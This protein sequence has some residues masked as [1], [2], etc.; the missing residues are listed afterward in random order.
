M[1][2]KL[3]YSIIWYS[4]IKDIVELKSQEF[5]SEVESVEPRI[6]I[7]KFTFYFTRF[8]SRIRV[9]SRTS[10]FFLW[11]PNLWFFLLFD[12]ATHVLDKLLVQKQD[13]KNMSMKNWSGSDMAYA[14]YFCLCSFYRGNNRHRLNYRLCW[15]V[16]FLFMEVKNDVIYQ[17]SKFF[18][19]IF[20]FIR[21]CTS[22]R[23]RSFFLL[24]LAFLYLSL[25]TSSS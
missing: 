11:R 19:T 18:V 23:D 6:K 24:N 15:G 21:T 2:K 14:F 12:P 9:R 13:K 17:C 22:V 8:E 3:Y 10:L 16:S 7:I 4:Q 20:Y 1:S 25:W 5:I